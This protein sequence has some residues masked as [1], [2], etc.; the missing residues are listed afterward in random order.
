MRILEYFTNRRIQNHGTFGMAFL[1]LIIVKLKIRQFLTYQCV[2]LKKVKMTNKI[3][4]KFKIGDLVAAI[5]HPFPDIFFGWEG[6]SPVNIRY[7]II[8]EGYIVAAK[9][10]WSR[11]NWCQFLLIFHT[12]LELPFGDNAMFTTRH[13]YDQIGGF[14]EVYLL[15]DVLMVTELSVLELSACKCFEMTNAYLTVR[16]VWLLAPNSSV[17]GTLD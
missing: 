2:N 12:F 8:G 6:S 17:N 14:Q 15:E 4:Y 11:W 7:E 13:V 10:R 5:M 3:F 16:P 9:C 1:F